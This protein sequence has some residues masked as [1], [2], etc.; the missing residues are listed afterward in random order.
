MLR[1][2][3]TYLI[4][5]FLIHAVPAIALASEASGEGGEH[6]PSIFDGG[7][8]ETIFAVVLFIV[9]FLI[10][11][12]WAWGPILSGLQKREE[13]IRQSIEDAD[14][15]KADAE[16]S[17][18][19]YQEKLAQSQQEARDILEKGRADA[20]KLADELKKNAQEEAGNI[21]IQT[22]RD[23]EQAKKQ[24]IAEIHEQVAVLATE[25]AGK[26]IGKTLTLEDQ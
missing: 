23:I 19:D 24:A 6:V 5:A 22:Q 14:K 10:L 4:S 18:K 21:R 16:V 9:I 8:F 7:P 11:R 12:K 13:Y 25:L 2:A 17:L 26:I 1:H 20:N 3:L 15:A